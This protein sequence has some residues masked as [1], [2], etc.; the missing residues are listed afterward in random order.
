MGKKSIVLGVACFLILA[1]GGILDAHYA[2]KVLNTDMDDASQIVATRKFLMQ[3]VRGNM[4]DMNKKLKAGNIADTA[5][6]GTDIA[7]LA[8][9]LPPLF[10]EV[11]KDRY[12][13]E[14]SKT[15]FKGAAPA[16]FES[17]ADKMRAAGMDI[18]NAA[19]KGDQAGV[20]AGLG[21]L[22]SSCGGCHSAF[23]G[24]Y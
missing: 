17:A 14:G 12:P 3:A 11:Y 7:A 21:A 15:Y 19:E 1:G 24:K 10:K 20:E 22:K 23:R 16:A 18:N 9:V 4:I 8:V 13:F 2:R 5:T 6:N